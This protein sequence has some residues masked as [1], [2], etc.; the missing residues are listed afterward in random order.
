M[1]LLRRRKRRRWRSRIRELKGRDCVQIEK[2]NVI[3][4]VIKAIVEVSRS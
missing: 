3:A 2:N 1:A 4:S